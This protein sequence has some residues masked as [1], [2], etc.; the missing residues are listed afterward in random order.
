MLNPMDWLIISVG[1]QSRVDSVDIEYMYL[2]KRVGV[3][4]SDEIVSYRIQDNLFWVLSYCFVRLGYWLLSREL[5]LGG[6]VVVF[7]LG[8]SPTQWVA[9]FF[10]FTSLP[11]ASYPCLPVLGLPSL[12]IHFPFLPSSFS[13]PNPTPLNQS[14][15]SS[16]HSGPSGLSEGDRVPIKLQERAT[17]FLHQFEKFRYLFPRCQLAWLSW[18]Q[19][20]FYDA[21]SSPPLKKTILH[22]KSIIF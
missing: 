16:F 1:I 21:L 18:Q 9:F 8:P 4:T 22:R 10:F 5:A 13:L 12:L 2:I 14:P 3:S 11:N 7:R 6:G 15:L 20:S 17:D 19:Q